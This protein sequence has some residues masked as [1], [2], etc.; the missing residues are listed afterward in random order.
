MTEDE[1]A[2]FKSLEWSLFSFIPGCNE[3][4]SYQ[5]GTSTPQYYINAK[6]IVVGQMA[7]N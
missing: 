5:C 1:T 4:F 3:N 6:H 7:I 2:M